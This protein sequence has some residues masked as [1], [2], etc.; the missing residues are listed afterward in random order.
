MAPKR[1]EGQRKTTP[2]RVDAG[3]ARKAKIAAEHQDLDLSDYISG[4][5]RPLVEKD[6]AKARKAILDA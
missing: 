4:L 1:D 5:L 6:W 2:I 3:L